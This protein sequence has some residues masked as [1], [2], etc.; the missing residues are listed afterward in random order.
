LSK[1]KEF[2]CIGSAPHELASTLT[3][4]T[5]FAVEL[6]GGLFMADNTTPSRSANMEKAE[7]NR[8][9]AEQ[10]IQESESS[11][12]AGYE[13]KNGDN[14]GGIT[15]RPLDQEIDNQAELPHRGQSKNESRGDKE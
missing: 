1:L 10:N 5:T 11:S 9:T 8:S 2:R 14:A 13:D 12:G 3:V 7:G 6:S 4:G 15:N